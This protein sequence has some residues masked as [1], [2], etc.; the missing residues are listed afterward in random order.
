MPSCAENT[1]RS[2]ECQPPHRPVPHPQLAHCS[3]SRPRPLW[4]H[5]RLPLPSRHTPAPLSQ[6][7]RVLAAPTQRFCR[8]A[9]PLQHRGVLLTG[10]HGPLHPLWQPSAPHPLRRPRSVAPVPLSPF[11]A[12]V[13]PSCT[14]HARLLSR[15]DLVHNGLTPQAGQHSDPRQ[16]SSFAG[17]ER[18]APT[19][20]LIRAPATLSPAGCFFSHQGQAWHHAP[21]GGPSPSRPQATRLQPQRSRG[22]AGWLEP[23]L[24]RGKD[25]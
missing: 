8:T 20:S 1:S 10:H 9:A 5:S 18:T 12:L 22:R 14:S 7:T 24:G 21:P 17:P 6:P 15:T 23:P 19:S 11:L 25:G 3:P 13:G 2:S 16:S 4:A